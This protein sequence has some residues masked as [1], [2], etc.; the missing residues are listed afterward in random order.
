MPQGKP[1]PTQ[2]CHGQGKGDEY[3]D[4]IQNHQNADMSAR[5]EEDGN[6]RKTNEQHAIT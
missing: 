4:A 1:V 3:I 5:R 2:S 6:S